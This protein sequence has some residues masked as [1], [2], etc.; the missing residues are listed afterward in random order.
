M[1]RLSPIPTPD[2]LV[3]KG[4]HRPSRHQ[5]GINRKGYA[6]VGIDDVARGEL[7]EQMIAVVTDGVKG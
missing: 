1:S 5:A 7:N 6:I 3:V 2:V 4:T